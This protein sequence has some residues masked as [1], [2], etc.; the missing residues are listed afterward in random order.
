M[1][2]I[3]VNGNPT[4]ASEVN[5]NFYH[6]AQGSRL[7]MGG[8]SLAATT[9]A[10]DLGT[11]TAYW[12][13]LFV[14]NIYANSI[15]TANKILWTL[16]SEVTLTATASSIEFTGL[17]GD[18][19]KEYRIIG[20]FKDAVDL[21]NCYINGDSATANYGYQYIYGENT[22]INAARVTSHGGFYFSGGDGSTGKTCFSDGILQGKTNIPKMFI[23]SAALHII[24]TTV[25]TVVLYDQ[26]YNNIINTITSLKFGI[27]NMSPNT[28]IQLWKRG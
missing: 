7:P 21:I 28:N 11:A 4:D 10:Y 15:T 3:L 13:N 9:L 25:Y 14:N 27:A 18:N 6:V 1:F 8:V 26:N 17:N 16:V 12:N 19:D 20:I 23:V 2:T 24:S 22:V 5:N